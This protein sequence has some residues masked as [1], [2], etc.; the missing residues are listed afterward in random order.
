MTLNVR[1]RIV[2]PFLGDMPPGRDGVRHFRKLGN[3]IQL[4][5]ALWL[6][7]LTLAALR[8]GFAA[9]I[10]SIKPPER[11]LM[12]SIHI[13]RR[14]YSKVKVDQ[15]ESFRKGTILGLQMDVE[16]RPKA[17]ASDQV[18][19]LMSYVGDHLG[20]SPWGSKFGFGRFTVLE[21]TR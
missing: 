4:D 13:Y 15:F 6:E 19:H 7:Q 16:Q 17:P 5:V 3:C 14:E 11:L 21:V 9:D 20:L 10:S 18:H 8:T 1:L 12:A 2:S